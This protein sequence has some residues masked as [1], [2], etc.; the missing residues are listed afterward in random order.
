MCARHSLISTFLFQFNFFASAMHLILLFG[1]LQYSI[2][3]LYTVILNANCQKVLFFQLTHWHIKFLFLSQFIIF[4]IYLDLAFYFLHIESRMHAF[5]L[6]FL[7]NNGLFIYLSYSI[8][9]LEYQ[10]MQRLSYVLPL[11]N[12]SSCSSVHT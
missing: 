10:S 2:V 7:F 8:V 3:L 4:S 1:E 12:I 6:I 11:Q 9:A 5:V